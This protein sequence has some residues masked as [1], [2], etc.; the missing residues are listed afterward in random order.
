MW[1]SPVA[2]TR[3]T[4]LFPAIRQTRIT[5]LKPSRSVVELLPAESSIVVDYTVISTAQSTV[6]SESDA[7][8]GTLSYD[9][10]DHGAG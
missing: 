3:R 7:E 5:P 9:V 2:A 1:L 4:N 10:V 6:D 8:S